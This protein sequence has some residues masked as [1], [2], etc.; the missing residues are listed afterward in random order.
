MRAVGPET[1]PNAVVPAE[2]A[3]LA[4]MGSAALP[5]MVEGLAEYLKPRKCQSCYG[6]GYTPCPACH[7]RGRQGGVFPGQPAAV[8]CATCGSRGRVRCQPCQHTGLANFW[9]WQPSENGGW[10]ARGQ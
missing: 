9:L 5:Y 3:A 8:P 6:A 2:V 4:V 1:P 7:G 10:G